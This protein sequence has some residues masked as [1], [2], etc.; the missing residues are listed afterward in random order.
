M[1][2]LSAFTANA[3]VINPQAQSGAEI[4]KPE[5]FWVGD[6]FFEWTDE[7]LIVPPFRTKMHL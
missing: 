1:S 4:Q 5:W 6:T 2:V 3:Q 7:L